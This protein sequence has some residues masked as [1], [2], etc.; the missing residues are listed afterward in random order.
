MSIVEPGAFWRRNQFIMK[1]YNE[2]NG[3]DAN[4]SWA[5]ALRDAIR[6]LE[7]MESDLNLVLALELLRRVL[8]S[9]ELNLEA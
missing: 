3:Q 8:R 1:T 2:F 5:E 4:L 6:E 7:E 9:M